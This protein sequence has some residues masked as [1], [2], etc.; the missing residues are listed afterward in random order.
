MAEFLVKMAD[1]QG[2]VL[3]QTES[4]FSEKEI[5]ERYAQQGYLVYS[6]KGQGGLLSL[7]LIGGGPKIKRDEFIIFNQQFVTLIKAGLPILMGINLLSKRQRNPYF[8]GILEN[9]K[10]RLKSGQLLSEA[11]EAQGQKVVSKVYTTTL[12][13]GEKS[14]NLEEVL[15]RYIEY[16]RITASFRKKLLASLW[17]P[18]VLVVA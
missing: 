11:F 13:A 1:E 17:Y 8:K 9:V 7:N 10:E 16:Q 15:S 5:R 18:A 4:G 6:V 2:R 12:L 14:G 3:E